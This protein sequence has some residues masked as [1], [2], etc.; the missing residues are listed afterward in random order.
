MSWISPR[1]WRSAE[2]RFND[3]EPL[4][5]EAVY[6]PEVLQSIHDQGFD[7]IWMRGRL[8]DLIHSEICPELNDPQAARRITNIKK[9]ISSGLEKGVKVYLYFNEPLGLPREH[10]FWKKYP[11]LAGEPLVEPEFD[12]DVRAFCTSTQQFQNFFNESIGNLFDDLESLGGVILITASEYHSHCWSHTALRKIGD[13]YIDRCVKP[14][15]CPNCKNREPADVVAELVNVWK[16]QADRQAK[17]PQVW[18]WN[19]SWSMWYDQPQR[20]V[21]EQLPAGV[22]L[23]CD[24]E[25][26]GSR[27]QD[28]GNV[29]IDEYSLGYVG[30][31]ER[32]LGSA[33]AA[34]ENNIEVCGKLQVG[35][36]HEL[37]TVPNIPLIPNLFDKLQKVDEL[38]LKGLMYSWNFGNS[39]SLNTAAIKLFTERSEFRNDKKKFLSTLAQIYFGSGCEDSILKAW[40]LFCLSFNEYPFAI[41]MLYH[42]PMNYSVAYPLSLKYADRKMGP[43][44]IGHAPFGD[45][46]EDC[47][48]P[49]SLSQACE[50]FQCMDELWKKG[51]ESYREALGPMETLN[52]IAELSC[53]RMIGCHILACRNIFEFH[54]WRREKMAEQKLVGPC[55]LESDETSAAITKR[56][57]EVCKKAFELS[58]QNA[59]FGYHQEP[60]ESF[61]DSKTIKA[62]ILLMETEANNAK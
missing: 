55:E 17:P 30:P 15:Q 20:E 61:Y 36:T 4:N 33:Q 60:H 19:W 37:A 39:P 52:S 48:G 12:W 53:A 58:Q 40:E 14:M 46:L 6:R 16:T 41:D 38:G 8:W 11:G 51:L 47:L 9:V 42:G 31:S 43:S 3:D 25:R 44:W 62:C 27:I 24:F 57:I 13:A 1:I 56:Q 29:F 59:H 49:F 7:A 22:K 28:I 10:R 5:C 23:M 34:V 54:K 35:V 21:I 26:G 45:R 50:C 2:S 18:A 32:F